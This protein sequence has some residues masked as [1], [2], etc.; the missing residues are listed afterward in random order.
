MWDG[1]GERGANGVQSPDSGE[2]QTYASQ[3][4]RSR[5]TPVWCWDMHVPIDMTSTAVGCNRGQGQIYCFDE[6]V[7]SAVGSREGRP[8]SPTAAADM[9]DG[10]ANPRTDVSVFPND[11]DRIPG[12]PCI[13]AISD[14]Q[15][16]VCT[17]V[18]GKAV[19]MV[20]CTSEYGGFMK[21]EHLQSTVENKT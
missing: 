17:S 2:R 4:R 20:P 18:C 15:T 10:A 16:F 1:D 14:G 6:H 7:P 21:R 3:P 13:L 5:P 11:M 9:V 12:G 19:S 8:G